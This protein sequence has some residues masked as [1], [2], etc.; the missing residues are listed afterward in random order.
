MAIPTVAADATPH[1]V[2]PN[3]GVIPLHPPAPQPTPTDP[4]PHADQL[5]DSYIDIMCELGAAT[6]QGD[7][8]AA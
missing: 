5:G 8:P 3:P 6:N 7:V 2:S 4:W 1:P